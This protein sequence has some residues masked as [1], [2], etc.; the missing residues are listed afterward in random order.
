[1]RNRP[2]AR[3]PL[4][5]LSLALLMTVPRATAGAPGNIGI[6]VLES[7]GTERGIRDFPVSVGLVFRQDE[8]KSVPGGR[9][10]DGA[11]RPVPFEAEATGWWDRKSVV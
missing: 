1:M 10:V 5:I 9:L 2:S 7:A 11:G 8:L 3:F 4:A 6:D